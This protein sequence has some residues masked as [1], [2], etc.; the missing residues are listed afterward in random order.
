VSFIKRIGYSD[1][2]AE[3]VKARSDVTFLPG[4]RY[5]IWDMPKL[6]ALLK[7]DTALR[8]ALLANLGQTTSHKM[9]EITWSVGRWAT[10]ALAE[11][12]PPHLTLRPW[13]L[14]DE[15]AAAFAAPP[16]PSPV[17]PF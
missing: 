10:T 13:T 14:S 11:P 7:K 8:N 4:S 12:T 1:D 2:R 16:C 15:A 9:N 6:E 17:D 3:Q 5:I